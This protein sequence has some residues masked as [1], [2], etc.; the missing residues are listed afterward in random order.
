MPTAY[1]LSIKSFLT[2]QDQPGTNN[3]VPDPNNPTQTV[4]LTIDKAFITNEIHSEV[5]AMEQAIGT[6]GNPPTTIPGTT[7]MG[8]EINNL[9][10]GKASG[11][12]DPSNNAIYPSG[13]PT[14]HNHVHAQLSDNAADVHP[15]Y[16]RVDGTRGFTAP[17]AAPWGTALNHLCPLGQ[18]ESVG[19][20]NF[21][22]VA[23][24]VAAQTNKECP[25]PMVCTHDWPGMQRYRM[26][27]GVTAGYT[28]AN[29]V[30]YVDYSAANYSGI[31]S[32]IYI[33]MPYPLPS[34]YGYTYQYEEDQLMLYAPITNQG[35]FIQFSE[36]IVVDRQAWVALCWMVLGV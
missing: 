32:F 18:A 8:A 26:S 17:V 27:G 15:Q 34:Y 6:P 7:T 10:L 30:I 21:N 31:A 33:K 20:L 36:D 9:F 28:D 2:F 14:P 22:Q 4:D 24:I 12:V 13:V 1:P 25:Y 11:R 3:I 5:L 35:A 29:G 16:I 23:F 19:W